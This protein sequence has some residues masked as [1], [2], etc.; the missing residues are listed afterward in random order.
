[1]YAL[2]AD[3]ITHQC[4]RCYLALFII[5]SQ[6]CLSFVGVACLYI[7]QTDQ[8]VQRIAALSGNCTCT[9]QMCAINA[10]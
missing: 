8:K 10:M 3:I 4:L 9:G 1:M 6:H 2:L 5:Q 7:S